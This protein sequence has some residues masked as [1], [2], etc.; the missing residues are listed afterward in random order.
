MCMHSVQ[1]VLHP[2][3]SHD[4]HQSPPFQPYN[5]VKVTCYQEQLLIGTVDWLEQFVSS[6]IFNIVTWLSYFCP[7]PDFLRFC[8]LGLNL[9]LPEG[10][11]MYAVKVFCYAV[12]APIALT[13]EKFCFFDVH[14][15]ISVINNT[16]WALFSFISGT[17]N[18]KLNGVVY[19]K[20]KSKH[21]LF[22]NREKV[23]RNT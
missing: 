8:L 2:V 18:G 3:T 19:F 20:C 7:N 17:N 12:D 4:S 21:G 15:T 10:W 16:M 13:F 11:F 14:H 22:V 5:V 9:L 1:Q 6:F 23:V